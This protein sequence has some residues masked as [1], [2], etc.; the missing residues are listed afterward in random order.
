MRKIVLSLILCAAMV[1]PTAVSADG[2]KI[3]VCIDGRVLETPTDAQA[4]NG[5]TMLPMRAV[6]EAL[7]AKVTWEG[8][9]RL[10]FATK[11]NTFI[12]LKI[13]S[14]QMVVQWADSTESAVI[15]LDAAPYL[16]GGYTFVPVRAVAESLNARV[17][18]EDA[19][20]TVIITKAA[21]KKD[22]PQ[23]GTAEKETEQSVTEEETAQKDT[24]Q[25]ETMQKESAQKESAQKE[26]TQNS[27]AENE[28]QSKSAQSRLEK[29][30][31]KEQG[32][33]EAK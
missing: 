13:D 8:K 14:P 9:D 3:T 19:T 29:V 1:F 12:T 33:E 32:Q 16:Y 21:G 31:T 30:Q 20:R 7:G 2:G 27:A 23:S 4:V 24:T 10:V 5:R 26:N 25:K 15:N 11:G 28:L 18:W 17:D 22:V 6:F